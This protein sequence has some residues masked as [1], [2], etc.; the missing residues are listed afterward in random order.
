MSYNEAFVSEE[1]REPMAILDEEHA[2]EECHNHR[3]L[4]FALSG[5]LHTEQ[6]VKHVI[7]ACLEDCTE[8][9]RNDCTES[10]A[11]ENLK[12]QEIIDKSA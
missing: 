12:L 9:Q 2:P 4:E 5:V 8:K 11:L 1:E 10:I 6:A 3:G 7:M